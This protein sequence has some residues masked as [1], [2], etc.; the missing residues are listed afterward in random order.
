MNLLC[1]FVSFYLPTMLV[2]IVEIESE[3]K[4]NWTGSENF[5]KYL[6]VIFDRYFQIFI[7]GLKTSH[8][9]PHNFE[10]YLKFLGN[11]FNT[12]T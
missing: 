9:N 3:I 4:R 2:I 5:D 11:T 7:S 8:Q 6:C 10:I 12:S 1:S